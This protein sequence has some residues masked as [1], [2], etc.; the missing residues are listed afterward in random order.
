M[1]RIRVIAPLELTEEVVDLAG[2]SVAVTNLIVLP[3]VARSP[4]GDMVQFELAREAADAMLSELRELG[5]HECGSIAVDEVD[6][7]ISTGARK[8]EEAAPGYDDDA[9]IWDELDARTAADARLSWVFMAFLV[10]ATQIAAIGALLDQPILIVG[11]MVLGPEFGAVAA[12]CFGVVHQN[13]ARIGVAVRTLAIGFTTA[14]AVTALCATLVAW[15]GWIHPAMLDHR[16]MTDFIVHP[17]RW[18]FIVALLAG[19]AGMLSLTASK[20]SALVGVFISVTTVPAAGNI[21]VA[22]P[23]GHFS[24]VSGSA[25]QLGV[26]LLGMLVAGVVTL[27]LQRALWSRYGIRLPALPDHTTAPPHPATQPA[28]VASPQS[29]TRRP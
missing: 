3:G 5:L 20:S 26:N 10:L 6:M 14:I 28:T 25:A 7:S 21:A 13:P 18:S 22:I 23:L 15:L 9:V 4:R 1:L 19:V 29:R 24:E 17:D 12:I 27:A 2:G 11:A 8:A 16:P